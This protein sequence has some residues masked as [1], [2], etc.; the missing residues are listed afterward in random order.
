MDELK[1]RIN[2]K[3]KELNYRLTQISNSKKDVRFYYVDKAREI[4][5]DI[6]DLE[7]QV[8]YFD[9]LK[10]V[11]IIDIHGANK[12]FVNNYL[13]DL[14]EKKFETYNLIKLITGK[15]TLILFNYVKKFLLE[16]DY[17]YK[18]EEYSFILKKL[19]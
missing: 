13:I 1:Y 5:E 6:I 16:N 9:N 8:I 18:I 12:Y 10:D 4:R 7:A 15:G 19:F 11:N 17:N 2:Q 3:I 14:I